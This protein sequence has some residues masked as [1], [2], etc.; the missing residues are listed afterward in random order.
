MRPGA[1]ALQ[2]ATKAGCGTEM[3]LEIPS[4]VTLENVS[5]P[6]GEKHSVAFSDEACLA[7]EGLVL[8]VQTEVVSR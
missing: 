2:S 5:Y 1:R 7:P 3:T 8:P 4:P 6:R